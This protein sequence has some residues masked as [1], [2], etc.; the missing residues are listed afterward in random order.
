MKPNASGSF[1]IRA[2]PES[3]TSIG[4]ASNVVIIGTTHASLKKIARKTPKD[5]KLIPL[6]IKEQ[7]QN[8]QL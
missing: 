2:P 6:C 7:Y 8:T 5:A 1:S 4:Y 3:K